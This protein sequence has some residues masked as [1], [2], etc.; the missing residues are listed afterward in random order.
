[1]TTHRDANKKDRPAKKASQAPGSAQGH[2]SP[3]IFPACPVGDGHSTNGQKWR[4]AALVL[5]LAAAARCF[6]PELPFQGSALEMLPDRAMARAHLAGQ[7]QPAAPE[8]PLAYQADRSELARMTYAVLLLT[9][10]VLWAIGGAI[11]GR[12]E[13]RHGRLAAAIALLAVLS[14]ASAMAASNRRS[15]L[16]SWIEQL[17]LMA[18]AF[19]A[20]QLCPGRRRFVTLVVVLAAVGATVAARSYWQVAVEAPQN[21]ADFEAHRLERLAQFG[22]EADTPQAQVVEARVRDWSAKGFFGLANP[23]GSLLIVLGF[24]AAGLAIDKFRAAWHGRPAHES[25]GRLGPASMDVSHGRDARATPCGPAQQAAK[26][27]H[28]SG[29][30][31]PTTVA[32]VA[33]A[34]AA[35]GILA[36]IPLTRSE[37]AMIAAAVAGAGL[38]AAL[39][40][41]DALARRWRAWAAGAIA[42]LVLA[43]AALLAYGLWHDSLP[44]KSMTFRWYYWTASAKMLADRPLLG[45]GPDNFANAYLKYRRDQAE[46]EIQNPHNVLVHALAEYGVPGGAC[47]LAVLG[48]LILLAVRPGREWGLAPPLSGGACPHFRTAKEE[49]KSSLSPFFVLAAVIVAMLAA[50]LGLWGATES[51][52]IVLLHTIVPAAVLAAMLAMLAWSG[53]DQHALPAGAPAD[54]ARMALGAAAVGFLVHNI[55]EWSLWMPGAATAFYLAVGAAAGRGAGLPASIVRG[56]WAIAGAGVAG[57]LATVMIFWMPVAGKTFHTA[58]MLQALRHHD[59]VGALAEAQAAADADTL[60]PR[61]A[62]DAA[63]VAMMAAARARAAGHEQTAERTV[64]QALEFAREAVRRD[65]ADPA[66]YRLA[67]E[68]EWTAQIFRDAR[69]LELAQDG[70]KAYQAGSVDKARR[71]WLAA[72]KL[73]PPMPEDILGVGNFTKAVSLNPKSARL[74]LAC[75]NN[76]LNANLPSKAVEQLDEAW[77]LNDVLPPESAQRLRPRELRLIDTLGARAAVLMGRRL[78]PTT[79]TSRATSTMPSLPTGEQGR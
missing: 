9:A 60:D 15:A 78:G 59:I 66:C 22:W 61:P 45:T 47:Y 1:M 71:D 50:R 36:V 55:V 12:L 26:P 17:S 28:G 43:G 77:R 74:R 76:F 32:A 52:A 65:V 4:A 46:E 13:V 53:R 63:E 8:N 70:D 38:L 21:V 18:A 11:E 79:A 42:A 49:Q 25:Q 44:T 41:R 24:A 33:A 58:G 54:A 14:L 62:A 7:T 67:G 10:G 68:L 69:L 35:V 37:G 57:V 19:L 56:R 48:W 39:I 27:R 29:E 73:L 51:A 75:A 64:G 6:V 2:S 30:V 40:W 23:F 72:A 20:I 31:E 34:L 5:L 16:D 3:G